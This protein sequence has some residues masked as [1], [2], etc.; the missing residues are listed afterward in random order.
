[1]PTYTHPTINI[2]TPTNGSPGRSD[3]ATLKSLFPGAPGTTDYAG[4]EGAATYKQAAL[5]LL[6]SGE[7][8]DNLQTG[9][10]D[11]DFGAAASDE[12][13]KPP[14]LASVATGGGGLPASPWV[15][16]PASPGAG[17]VDPNDQP[18]PP[19]GFGT[20]PTNSIANVGASSDAT[21]PSRDPAT[22]SQRMSQGR[23]VGA[24]AIGQSPATA[25]A[26]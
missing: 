20:A 26:S 3:T 19:E 7:V 12:S 18:A 9:T 2:V 24:Y 21:Q 10:V 17:S 23:E 4:T 8:T 13:R 16:N 15:P 11:R 6:L 25:N 1:M 14:T 5:N 22:S